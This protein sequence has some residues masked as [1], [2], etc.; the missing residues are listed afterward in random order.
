MPLPQKVKEILKRKPFLVWYVKDRNSLSPESVL[1][2]VLNYGDW[3]DFLE[4][5]DAIGIEKTK[6]MFENLKNRKRVNLRPATVNYFSNYFIK[7]A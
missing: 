1:E 7:Y 3:Q 2:S 4:I 5:K 6:S